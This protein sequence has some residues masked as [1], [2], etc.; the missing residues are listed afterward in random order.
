MNHKPGNTLFIPYVSGW[1]RAQ[2]STLVLFPST[3]WYVNA[4]ILYADLRNF[5]VLSAAFAQIPDG[6]ERLHEILTD[7]FSVVVQTIT[8]YNGDVVAIAGDALTVWWPDRV[9]LAHGQACGTAMLAALAGLPTIQTP[10]GFFRLDL[11]IGVAAGPTVVALVGLPTYGV[12][13]AVF[14]PALEAATAAKNQASTGELRVVTSAAVIPL[15]SAGATYMEMTGNGSAVPQRVAPGPPDVAVT[16]TPSMPLTLKHFLPPSFA[17]RLQIGVLLAEYRRCIPAFAAFRLPETAAALHDLVAR[18]QVIAARWGGWL[19]E[20]EIGDKGPVFVLLFGAPVAHGDDPLR[21][22]GCC[23]ELQARNLITRAGITIGTLFVGAVGCATRRVY[24]V[25]GS[26]MNLAARLMEEAMPG[27]ILISGRMRHEVAG[28]YAFDR[29]MFLRVK[30]LENLVPVVRVTTKVQRYGRSSDAPFQRYLADAVPLIGRREERAVLHAALERAAAGQPQVVIVE[31]E[32]GIGKSSLLR[33]TM[34]HWLQRGLLAYSG[35]C[36]SNEQSIPGHPWRT[37][38]ADLCGVDE[39][40]SPAHQRQQLVDLLIQLPLFRPVPPEAAAPTDLS[41]RTVTIDHALHLLAGMLGLVETGQ[42]AERQPEPG[43]RP[44]AGDADEALLLDLVVA[45]LQQRLCQSPRLIL[46][47]DIHWA[48]DF[49]LRLVAR[50]A[51]GMLQSPTRPYPLLLLLSHRPLDYAPPAAF[52]LLCNL[53]NCQRLTVGPLAWHEQH[54]LLRV[55]LGAQDLAPGLSMLVE[56]H[57]QGQPLFIKEYVRM[58]LERRLVDIEHGLARLTTVPGDLQLSDTIQG[59]IQARVDRL[60]ETT[61]LTL[62]VAAV[63]GATFPLALLHSIHPARL[64]LPALLAQ[65]EHLCTL[66]ILDLELEGAER[67]YRFKY[68]ITHEVAYTSLLFRQRRTLHAAIARWYEQ[69]YQ[70][71]LYAERVAPVLYGVLAYHHGRAENHFAQAHYCQIASVHAVDRYAH[72]MALEYLATALALTSVPVARYDLLVLRIITYDRCG[73]RAA[74]E[75]DIQTLTNLAQRLDDP[76]RRAYAVWCAL[77]YL[78]VQGEYASA[79]EQVGLVEHHITQVLEQSSAATTRQQARLLQAA[80]LDAQGLARAGLGDASAARACHE[81]ALR[82]Y[83]RVTLRGRAE[84][85]RGT[86]LPAAL[87]L[88]PLLAPHI[89]LVQCLNGLGAACQ[90]LGE[91]T[92]ARRYHQQA[93]V[94]TREREDWS[95]EASVLLLLCQADYADQAY[96]QAEQHARRAL[97]T[98]LA[99]GERL[100]QAMALRHL[101]RIKT[102]LGDYDDAQRRAMHALS[103]STGIGARFL[104]AAILGDLAEI[105]LARGDPEEAQ[106]VRSEA[107]AV[108]RRLARA[109]YAE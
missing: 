66:A 51:A 99:T 38:L 86:A 69:R 100:T 85:R 97:M 102:A 82:Y 10:T 89:R 25:Q 16:G 57:T 95:G 41:P 68:R 78:L 32:S 35:E 49:S 50:F 29:L 47:E 31:G 33:E 91:W 54:E 20:V 8:A 14:G 4:T 58:L 104:D 109:A 28:R 76:L 3:S 13:L 108:L 15:G 88:S 43:V 53:P 83:R 2:L 59:I 6:A 22:V 24:T 79:L 17:E 26:E 62:K 63:I 37:V 75:Q 45:L 77:Q 44:R 48:D 94:I 34:L 23:L 73:D 87:L 84:T 5:S 70:E 46:L 92:R 74:Q 27:D 93:L 36:R 67:V 107:E 55:L 30:G 105:A 18:V 81:R 64:P 98:S 101:A 96:V 40:L 52:T 90:M 19:N 9:D 21:A 56:R 7:F 106:A 80:C 103:I 42:A 39:T 61:R 72:T 12:H 65:L 1:L 11:R 71:D 60:E